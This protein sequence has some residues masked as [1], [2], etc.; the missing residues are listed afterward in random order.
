MRCQARSL[1]LKSTCELDQGH[2]GWHQAQGITWEEYRT[3]EGPP[4]V[5]QEVV[6]VAD[7][8]RPGPDEEPEQVALF[9]GEA[10]HRL[11]I[12]L[13]G[14]GAV[15]VEKEIRLGDKGTITLGWE[16]VKVMV[17]KGRKITSRKATLLIDSDDVD[18][19]V[20]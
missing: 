14:A 4:P 19:S 18:L 10:V 11:R 13:G 8:E 5:D 16:C 17:H 12:A 9:E 20:G 15:E 1:A 3:A 6:R 7:E 2:V